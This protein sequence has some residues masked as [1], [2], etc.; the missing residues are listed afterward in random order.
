VVFSM[1][2]LK[3][4]GIAFH[5]GITCSRC[6]MYLLPSIPTSKMKPYDDVILV[7]VIITGRDGQ[8]GHAH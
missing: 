8:V 6:S 7:H 5:F 4:L 1:H 3:G 2:I